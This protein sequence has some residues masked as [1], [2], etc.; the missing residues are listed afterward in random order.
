MTDRP[1]SGHRQACTGFAPL[2]LG[3]LALLLVVGLSP[4]P[5]ATAQSFIGYAVKTGGVLASQ[6]WD[7][8]ER[9]PLIGAHVDLQVESVSFE[10]PT[11]FYAA[12]GYHPRGSAIRTRAFVFRDPNTGEE[13]RFRPEALRF[14]FHNA[15]LSVGGK[16]HYAVG[17]HRGFVSFALR[18]E[19]NLATDF[20]DTDDRNLNFGL[21]T[22]YPVDEFVRDFLYGVD[23]G[24]GL[25]LRV[26]SRVDALFEI[27]LSPDLSAQYEQPPLQ[28]VFN[29]RTGNNEGT[30]QRSINNL[31]VELSVGL[32]FLP[33]AAYE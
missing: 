12:V 8:F 14:V 4:K 30:A 29:P 24:A 21:G 26:S 22:T 31:S 32:R 9:D 1:T 18:G 28:N 17:G 5:A 27:K 6:R 23:V 16:Q 15:A 20:G 11:S 7:N 3:V 10:K 25:E 13:V 2:R 19:Y 33:D